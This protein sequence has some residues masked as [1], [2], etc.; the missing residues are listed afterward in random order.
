MLPLRFDGEPLVIDNRIICQP[1]GGVD[2]IVSC[3]TV[4]AGHLR[5]G[6]GRCKAV[7]SVSIR[8]RR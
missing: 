8:L 7:S 3:S 6:A 2:E 4:F 5:P 1:T